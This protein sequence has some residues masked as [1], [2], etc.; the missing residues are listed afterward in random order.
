MADLDEEIEQ[1]TA[2]QEEQSEQAQAEEEQRR[3]EELQAQAQ[4]QRMA[5]LRQQAADAV[6]NQVKKEAVDLAKKAIKETVWDSLIETFPY[7]GPVVG[8]GLLALVFLGIVILTPVVICN[9]SYSSDLNTDAAK[10]ALSFGGLCKYLKVNE[11]TSSATPGSGGGGAT[12]TFGGLDIVITSAYR[13]G[14]IVAG[15]NTLSAHSRGEAVDIALRNPTVPEHSSD[16][17]IAQLVAIAKSAGFTPAVGD[18][19]DEY[20][21][22]TEG[23]SGGHVHVEFNVQAN[24]NTYC[25]NTPA[26]T[27]NSPPT[28]LVSLSGA[29]P[30]D[31]AATDPRVRPCMLT[32]VEKIFAAA[33]AVEPTAT[34]TPT[35]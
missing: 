12:G 4:Q 17:R 13:A 6:K 11:I 27:L 2:L 23:A 32:A 3:Q 24:G 15:T 21:T 1:E 31:A 14:S 8:V 34:V 26:A 16:P 22:P 5:A 20:T 10:V 19:L 35:P 18:T 28:D 7:W 25:D 33:A 9:S 30:V 29:V